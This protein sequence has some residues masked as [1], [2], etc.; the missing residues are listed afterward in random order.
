MS[1]ETGIGASIISNCT[2]QGSG[3]NEVKG[4]IANRRDFIPTYDLTNTA[5]MTGL[6]LTV[7]AQLYPF[8]G[9]KKILN[10]GFDIVTDPA[11]ADEYTHYVGFTGF[12]YTSDAIINMDAM[13]D[14]VWV[15]ESKDKN[16]SGDGIFRVF[17]AK[18]GLV[19]TADSMRSNDAFGGRIIEMNSPDGEAEA[20]SN[21]VLLDTD[22]A[23]TLAL[24]EG[25]ETPVV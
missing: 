19:K 6:T 11:R 18:K 12:E 25:L 20:H 17:G 9:V 22:Y 14:L 23:T 2:T 16:D 21:Y 10:S 15:V 7:G 5:L 1:C 13:N 24:L 8:E 3:G 4:W